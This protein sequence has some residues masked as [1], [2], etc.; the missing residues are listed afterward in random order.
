MRQILGQA[1]RDEPMPLT[2]EVNVF[3][4]L[5]QKQ[6]GRI[7]DA[8]ESRDHGHEPNGVSPRDVRELLL[9]DRGVE[10]RIRGAGARLMSRSNASAS[11]N[12]SSRPGPS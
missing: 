10:E 9:E 4:Y 2:P 12:A 1:L 6:R 3:G 7:M 5:R 11:L 8:S